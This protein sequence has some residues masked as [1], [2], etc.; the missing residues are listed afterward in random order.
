MKKEQI[1][2]I[3]I[4][5]SIFILICIIVFSILTI[6]QYHTYI[7]TVNT[8]IENIVDEIRAQYPQV[9]EEKLIKI[10]KCIFRKLYRRRCKRYVNIKKIW[11]HRQQSSIHKRARKKY[12]TFDNN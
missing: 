8:T 10:I 5:S 2:K 11:I 1:K 4:P 3:L 12:E 6:Y 7:T 9:S